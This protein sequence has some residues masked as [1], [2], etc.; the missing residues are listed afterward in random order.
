MTKAAEKISSAPLAHVQGRGLVFQ[1][2]VQAVMSRSRSLT[3]R[4]T[5]RR[6][7]FAVISAN[8]LD[9]RRLVGGEVV[10]EQMHLQFGGDLPVNR[11]EE[12]TELDRPVLV[13]GLGDA[14]PSP[15]SPPMPCS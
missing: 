3:H 1:F 13:A 2:S 14:S 11:V 6:M 15:G 4:W 5:P 12:R 8:T 9:L 7:S 10:A